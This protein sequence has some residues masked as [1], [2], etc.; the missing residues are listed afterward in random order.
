MLALLKT[1]PVDTEAKIT[2]FWRGPPEAAFD[3]GVVA[4]VDALLIEAVGLLVEITTVVRTGWIAIPEGAALAWWAFFIE[5]PGSASFI[6]TPHTSLDH[7]RGAAAAHIILGLGAGV[8]AKVDAPFVG[9]T[10]LLTELFELE[11]GATVIVVEAELELVFKVAVAVE[12]VIALIGAVALALVADLA[13]TTFVEELPS[14]TIGIRFSRA[15]IDIVADTR[16]CVPCA[17]IY[18]FAFSCSDADRSLVWAICLGAPTQT[19]FVGPEATDES[20]LLIWCRQVAGEL[21][22]FCAFIEAFRRRA[23]V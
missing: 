11:I 4:H 12:Q 6:L 8:S 13:L 7:V 9:V 19:V 17:L 18:T 22:W 5:K 15:E 1:T 20:I 23:G 21:S 2:A 14:G 10:G 16:S 3:L